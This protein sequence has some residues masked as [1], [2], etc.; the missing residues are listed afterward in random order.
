MVEVALVVVPFV[1]VSALIVEE[2]ETMIPTVVVGARYP[3][4]SDQSL[5]E[6]SVPVVA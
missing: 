2:A 5:N 1:T 6:L 3:L 4:T